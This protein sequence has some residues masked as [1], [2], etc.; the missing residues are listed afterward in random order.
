MGASHKGHVQVVSA[1]TA[2]GIDV[3][4]VDEVPGENSFNSSLIKAILLPLNIFFQDGYTALKLASEGGHV[5]VVAALIA[6]GAN[7]NEAAEVTARPVVTWRV[8]C[9]VASNLLPIDWPH[10]THVGI[11]RWPS[12]DGNGADS[13][14]G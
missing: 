1:L 13:C 5:E 8:H 3:N 6:A 10:G 7:V 11:Q 14:R 12:G 9:W 2:A 4:A